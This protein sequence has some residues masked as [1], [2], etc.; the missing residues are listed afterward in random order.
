MLKRPR[1]IYRLGMV[2]AA[3]AVIGLVAAGC[4]SSGGNSGSSSGSEST[5]SGSTGAAEG[6]VA[7]P[8]GKPVKLGMIAEREVLGPYIAAVESAVNA[9]NKRGGLDGRPV[10]L[11]Q[12]SD[13]ADPNVTISCARKMVE[14]EVLA[15][16]GGGAVNGNVVV[17]IFEEAEI[18]S[19]GVTAVDPQ[20]LSGKDYF[21]FVGGSGNSQTIL[22]SYA[23]KIGLKTT[24]FV[25]EVPETKQIMEPTLNDAIAAGTP[26]FAEVEIPPSTADFAPV[27][28]KGKLDEAE[29]AL[30]VLAPNQEPPLLQTALSEG[31]S[32]IWL[33]EGEPGPEIAEAFGGTLTNIVFASPFG[34]VSPES[35]DPEVLR[36]LEELEEGAKE[37][38]SDAAEAAAHPDYSQ[39]FG[40][41]AVQVIAQLVEEGQL[42]KLAAPDLL[43]VLH[44]VKGLKIPLV[45]AWYPNEAGPEGFRG[46]NEAYEL[47]EINEG[48]YVPLTE[49]PVTAEDLISGKVTVPPP[50][51]AE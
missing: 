29:A 32:P 44:E 14:E 36:Y 51:T 16:V 19:I 26:L 45:G 22:I 33:I 43:K 2:L 1:G 46:G 42:E 23:S 39:A 15:M 21:P 40:W 3:I 6:G 13:K 8:S 20:E 47:T 10:E 24:L 4:G 30:L 49:E 37:G 5:E 9:L 28:A 7:Q 38:V 18:P 35:K 50:A 25:I 31:Y 27:L 41:L 17:P 48:K 34:V 11:V 12:C